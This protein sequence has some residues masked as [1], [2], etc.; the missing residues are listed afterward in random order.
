MR[1]HNAAVLAL[2]SLIPAAVLAQDDLS[3]PKRVFSDQ[4]ASGSW[5]RIRTMKGNIQ[6][7]ESTGATAVVTAVRGSSRGSTDNITFEVKRDGSNVTICAIY[8][9]TTRCDEDGYQ[10]RWRRNGGDLASIN[11][12]VELP[13]GV[14]ISASSGNGDVNVSGAGN[15]VSASSGNGEVRVLGSGGRVSAS[16]GN[17]DVEVS[18]ARGQ[19]TA[20]SGNGD[21]I[22]GTTL[23]PV[24]ASTGNGRIDVR[25]DELSSGDMRFSTG[26]GSIELRLPANLSADVVAN[27]NLRNFST[28]FPM[29]LPGRFS[30][31]RIEGTIGEGGRRITMSTGNGS[32]SLIKLN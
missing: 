20:S 2:F 11:F 28:D 23:G 27:V 16:T 19:V 7:R 29:T 13:K 6:V 3:S 17:G 5:L 1:R 30:G 9:H 18:N 21:L 14:K 15:E 10:S 32:V 22:V 25:M 12:T 24:S 4:V 26:N 8:P 31:R